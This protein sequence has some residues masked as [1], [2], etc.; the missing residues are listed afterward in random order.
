[1][2]NKKYILVIYGPN[3]NLIGLRKK[4]V[5]LD[6]LNRYLRKLV[7]GNYL[8]KVIQTNDESKAATFL[9]RYRNQA[10]GVI[11]LPGPWQQCGYV[12]K[13][14]LDLINLP[15]VTVS[16]GEKVQLL[17]GKESIEKEDLFKGCEKAVTLLADLQ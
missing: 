11:L 2:G 15:F 6:K 7:R 4:G 17:K 5:T 8:L 9:Q 10:T 13:D 16:S 3:M 12:L 14:A 1:M